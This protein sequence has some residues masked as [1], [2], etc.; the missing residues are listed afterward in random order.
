MQSIAIQAGGHSSRMGRDKAL[1]PL[2]G[3]PLIEHQIERLQGLAD[4]MII[5][6]NKPDDYAYLGLHMASDAQPGAGALFGL[7]TA[8]A[9][10]RAESVLVVACDM[11]FLNRALLAFL[12]EQASLADVV[13]PL[14]NAEFEPLH[15]VYARRCLTAIEAAL[16][17]QKR[18][19]ISF[20]DAVEV[21]PIEAGTWQRFDPQGR[22]FFN[23]NTPDDLAHAEEML[24][25]GD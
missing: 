1:V 2:G 18:R 10:T 9:A 17:Q 24:A 21:M 3:R 15:A 4:E 13:I 5:T 16:A 19:M 6:T 25:A 14:R 22:S 20:F 11:P 7:Q 12:L 8:L 23:I